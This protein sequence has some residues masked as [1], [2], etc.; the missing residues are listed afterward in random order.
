M[1]IF[2]WFL[3]HMSSSTEVTYSHYNIH[4]V[5]LVMFDRVTPKQKSDCENKRKAV[6]SRSASIFLTTPAT[7]QFAR[8]NVTFRL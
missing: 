1:F 8:E 3:L 7:T 4:E 5:L 6:I 2:L